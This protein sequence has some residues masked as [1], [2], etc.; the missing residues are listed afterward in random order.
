MAGN[1][2]NEQCNKFFNH[3]RQ[4][5]P[6]LSTIVSREPITMIYFVNWSQFSKKDY[7]ERDEDRHIAR[8]PVGR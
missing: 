8:P 1:S 4:C 2:F 7:R 6:E 5:L 3:C